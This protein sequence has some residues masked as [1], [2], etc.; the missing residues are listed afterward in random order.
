MKKVKVIRS[1]GHPIELEDIAAYKEDW[2][3]LFDKIQDRCTIGKTATKDKA[4]NM[5]RMQKLLARCESILQERYNRIAEWDFIATPEQAEKL[6]EKHGNI[7]LTRRADS[8][9]LLYVILD[10]DMVLA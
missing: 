10:E 6:I 2:K 4:Y 5:F 9:D 3:Q 7:M 1:S 8:G